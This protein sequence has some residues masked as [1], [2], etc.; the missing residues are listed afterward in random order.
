MY[1]DDIIVAAPRADD[2]RGIVQDLNTEFKVKDLGQLEFYL[3]IK[4]D[5]NR[6][7]GTITLSQ[8]R[9]IE[10]LLDKFG[11]ADCR[12]VSTPMDANAK[13]DKSM[14]ATSVNEV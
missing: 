8:E 11:M 4:V 2:I 6:E 3:G 9:Y 13:L 14:C 10:N 1:V 5:R 12:P 7:M